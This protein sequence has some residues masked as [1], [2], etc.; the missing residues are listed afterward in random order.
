[1]KLNVTVHLC[2]T[3]PVIGKYTSLHKWFTKSINKFLI[4]LTSVHFSVI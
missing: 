3:V 1:M 2:F 4:R